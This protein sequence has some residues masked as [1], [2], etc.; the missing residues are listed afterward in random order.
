MGKRVLVKLVY[1]IAMTIELRLDPLAITDRWR[2][3]LGDFM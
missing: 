1:G 3:R 2:C